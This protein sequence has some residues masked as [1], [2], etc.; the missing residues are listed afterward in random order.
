VP[1]HTDRQEAPCLSMLSV[2]LNVEHCDTLCVGVPQGYWR[3]PLREDERIDLPDPVPIS[4]WR[5]PSGSRTALTT[6]FAA[7]TAATHL[8][9]PVVPVLSCGL[10]GVGLIVGVW[11]ARSAAR[12]SEEHEGTDITTRIPRATSAARFDL[13][14]G[15]KLC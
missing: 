6:P 11:V 3:Q 8:H 10:V 1:I 5:W 4:S 15:A 2:R 7:P 12:E 13:A 9:T 14:L